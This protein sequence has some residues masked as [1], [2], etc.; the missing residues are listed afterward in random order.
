MWFAVDF[1]TPNSTKVH[2]WHLH[3][4]NLATEVIVSHTV[5]DKVSF[6]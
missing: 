6:H 4:I 3:L 2:I 5:H 1:L